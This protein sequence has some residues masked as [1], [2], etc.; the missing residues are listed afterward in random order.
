M[1]GTIKRTEKKRIPTGRPYSTIDC[2]LGKVEIRFDSA[3]GRMGWSNAWELL[4]QI[5]EALSLTVD[6][7]NAGNWGHTDYYLPADLFVM[8]KAGEE[9]EIEF[10]PFTVDWVLEDG[11]RVGRLPQF[12]N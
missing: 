10:T 7:G 8:I 11:R 5:K 12:P 4:E 9:V 1:I 2:K 3:T 6:P